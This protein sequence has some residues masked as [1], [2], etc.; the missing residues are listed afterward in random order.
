MRKLLLG[1]AAL[2]FLVLGTP[3]AAQ[4][5]RGSIEGTIKDS[6][7]GVLP[8]V[9]VEAAIAGGTAITTVTDARGVYRFPSLPPGTYTVKASLSGFSEA[10]LENVQVTLGAILT[11]DLN[12][13]P[14]GVSETVEVKASSPVIDVKQNAVT[15]VVSSEVIDLIP[16]TGTGILGALSGLPGAGAE[17]RLGG[18]GIDGAGAS[19]NRYIIDGMDVSGL[20]QRH[21]RP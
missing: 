3:A 5:T 19:E 21:A 17:G 15:N 16:K 7:G 8:G 20:Q 4:E 18:F 12:L 14:G 6:G 11:V 13:A 2:A 9:T 1:C 10:K